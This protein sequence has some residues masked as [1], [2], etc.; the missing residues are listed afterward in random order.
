MEN[1]RYVDFFGI[2][3]LFWGALIFLAVFVSC[4][5]AWKAIEWLHDRR[6]P[7]AGVAVEAG[8]TKDP[9]FAGTLAVYGTGKIGLT[10]APVGSAKPSRN[11]GSRV[12]KRRSGARALTDSHIGFPI[13]GP[14]GW[15]AALVPKNVW[16]IH[17]YSDC[18]NSTR[19]VTCLG[20]TH[21]W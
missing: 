21:S 11:A 6:K 12:S 14:Q 5:L 3:T 17:P 4:F 13:Q 9:R 19:P 18:S 2:S 8:H 16:L 20:P 7:K 10:T 1:D 15:R